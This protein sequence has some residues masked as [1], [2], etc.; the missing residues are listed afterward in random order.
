M[1]KLVPLLLCAL[2]TGCAV[3]PDYRPPQNSMPDHFHAAV[4]GPADAGVS[5][6]QIFW[7]G[8]QD[9]TLEHLIQLALA[10]N[11]NL[12][13]LL[14]RYE[15]AA[16]LL[17]LAR[18]DQLP[19]LTATGEASE[20]VLA[21]AEQPAAGIDRLTRYRLGA[22][23]QWELDLTGRLARA[24][25]ARRAEFEATAADL[26]ALQVAVTGQLA[27]A[28]FE[29]RGLQHQL[30][31]IE[32]NI[33][34]QQASL[35]IV[36][37]R[38]E[39]GRG[40]D[41]DQHRAR[42]QLDTTRAAAPAVHAAIRATLH[43]MAVLTGQPPQ[44]LLEELQP[45]PS[46]A[47]ALISAPS[48]AA[49]T[50][51]D[52]LRRRPDIIAAERRLAA[53]TARIGIATAD[54]F[55]RFTL[56]GLVGSVAASDAELFTAG[57]ESRRIALGVDWTFLDAARVKAR[58]DAADAEADALLAQY[59]QTVLQALEETETWLIRHQESRNR[60]ALLQQA[61]DSASKAVAEA[62]TRYDQGYSDYFQLLTA[63][64][65]LSGIRNER[66]QSQTQQALAMVSV[67][68]S[69]AGAP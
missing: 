13:A 19:H 49:G 6:S 40:T 45:R 46:E 36:T 41:F 30:N 7:Q 63:E 2:A 14:A 50:P 25:E 31:V 23:F 44:A 9:P 51:G 60:S 68:R 53:A 20:Q 56:D 39:A 61:E 28:Y 57:A 48:I 27:A 55:P 59:R 21:Q 43:R 42:A 64:L 18:R 1:T 38:R 22:A 37:A 35:D 67:Y 58:I 3:G 12:A 52:A 10:D 32:A 5:A 24:T 66:V 8:F 62:R 34:L 47:P 17:R 15:S 16:A 33:D 54:L 65:E 69:L 11:Q 26:Q 29:L 4:A